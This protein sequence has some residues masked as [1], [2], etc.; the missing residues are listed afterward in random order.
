MEESKYPYL[1]KRDYKGQE[2][3]IL[4]TEENF[5]VVVMSDIVDVEDLK[6]GKMG[7]FDEKMFDILPPDQ[8]VRLSN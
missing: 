5:G 2:Y 8:C 1:G 3:V 7:D 4:F 6:F